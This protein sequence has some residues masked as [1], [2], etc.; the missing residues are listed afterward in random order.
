MKGQLIVS[1]FLS[2]ICCLLVGCAGVPMEVNTVNNPY[3]LPAEYKRFTF[4][5]VH[6]ENQRKEQHLVTVVKSEMEGK[7]FVFDDKSPQFIVDINVS[8]APKQIQKDKNG[9]TDVTKKVELIFMDVINRRLYS[10]PKMVWRGE[11]QSHSTGGDFRSVD[12]ERC[13]VIGL[14]QAYPDRLKSVTKS[15]TSFSC[16]N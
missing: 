6:S 2:V 10:E 14:L 4:T 11:A 9:F 3:L 16:R 1:G 12:I 7:G 15:V 13:L 5:P 8:E